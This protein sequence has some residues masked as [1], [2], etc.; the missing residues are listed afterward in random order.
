VGIVLLYFGK[1]LFAYGQR[2]LM[3]WVGQRVILDIRVL[4]YDHIQRM[5]LSYIHGKR[6]GELLSRITNDVNVLQDMVT[7]VVVDLVVQGGTFLGMSA[8]FSTLT[9]N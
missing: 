7:S 6:V 2:Y 3:T 9:G 8:S 5:S 4:L 1:A